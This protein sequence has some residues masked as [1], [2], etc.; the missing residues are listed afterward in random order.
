MFYLLTIPSILESNDISNT[1]GI[2]NPEMLLDHGFSDPL[3]LGY[4]VA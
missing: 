2:R 4:V 1:F 3:V